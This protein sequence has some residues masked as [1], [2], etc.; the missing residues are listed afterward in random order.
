MKIIHI[1]ILKNKI[2]IFEKNFDEFNKEDK[3]K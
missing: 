1:I 2:Y 3:N